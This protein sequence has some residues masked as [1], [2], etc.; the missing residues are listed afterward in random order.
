V[1]QL[2]ILDQTR[3]LGG[4]E[5]YR[6]CRLYEAPGYVKEASVEQLCGPDTA[7]PHLFA[8]QRNRLFPMHTKSAVWVSAAFLFEK[9]AALPRGE[10]DAVESRL[11]AAADYWGILPQVEALKEKVAA[12]SRDDLS[13][14]PDEDFCWVQG[15]ER[16]LPMRNGLEVKAA[17]E[18]L[19]KWRDEFTFDDRQ[20][21]ARKVL[22][23]AARHGA[24]LGDHD[25]FLEKLAG[26][27][28][29]AAAT[30]AKLVRD[31]ATLARSREPELA[32]ELE[33]MAEMILKDPQKSRRPTSLA[34]IASTIDQLDRLLH[35]REYSEAVPRPEDV[36][37][38]VTRKTA[39]ALADQHMRTTTGSVY[40]VDD[41][42]K[43]RTQQVRHYLGDDL[44]RAVDSDGIHIDVTKAAEVIPTLPLG[45][46]RTFD[47]L[48]QD[49]GIR[50]FTKEAGVRTGL[51]R[52]DLRSLASAHRQGGST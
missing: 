51:T 30:A 20:L 35:I 16:Q 29:C 12:A 36:L 31:R 26:F 7:R 33:K 2:D 24:N 1:A 38:V 32:G 42:A 18:Y 47:Q 21:M 48:C 34:K 41:M 13:K 28:S 49:V 45:D 9:R 27:G 50:P 6:I 17:A 40:D 43:L 10:V 25:E 22:Q 15:G 4:Q 44:A 3:D 39:S 14:L 5:L 19:H 23:K 37:F 8:D 11:L 52:E 46:A